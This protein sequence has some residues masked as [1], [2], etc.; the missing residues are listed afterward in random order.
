MLLNSNSTW[1][2]RSP[3]SAVRCPLARSHA[4]TLAY[5]RSRYHFTLLP[6][7]LPPP[8]PLGAGNIRSIKNAIRSLG[9]SITPVTSIADIERADNLIFPGVGAFGQAMEAL[10]SKGYD[11]ALKE[12]LMLA[13]EGGEGGG[14]GKRFFGIC[15]GMQVRGGF[16]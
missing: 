9:Y 2:V 1:A 4:C 14:R 5:V 15:I 7:P 13:G 6:P 3:L 10:R 11:G 8:P 16:G 12:Y